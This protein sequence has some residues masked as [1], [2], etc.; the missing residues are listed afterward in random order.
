VDADTWEKHQLAGRVPPPRLM[1]AAF[2]DRLRDAIVM[3]GGA[4]ESAFDLDA[5]YFGDLWALDLE[6]LE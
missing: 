5:R 4:D 2:Y 1:H 3:Y 6:S